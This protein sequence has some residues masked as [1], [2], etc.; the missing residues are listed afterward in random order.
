MAKSK[1]MNKSA[2]SKPAAGAK[3][4]AAKGGKA[5]RPM[6]RSAIIAEVAELTEL[7]K[8]KVAEV[9]DVLTEMLKREVSA[10]GSGQF[11]LP[12]GLLTVKRVHRKER[13][14]RMGR[15]LRTGEPRAIPAKPAHWVVKAYALKSLRDLAGA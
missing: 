10:G 4:K 11:K 13:P 14:A 2:K 7:N 3:G 15:D 8:K 1:P 9:F 12:T 5:G 6:S